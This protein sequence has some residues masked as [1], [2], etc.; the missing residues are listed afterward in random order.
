MTDDD[1]KANFT[2]DTRELNEEG[3]YALAATL[4]EEGIAAIAPV[5]VATVEFRP[6][7]RLARQVVLAGEEFDLA[8]E[9]KNVAG[10]AIRAELV[11][12][13]LRQEAGGLQKVGEKSAT[14]DKESGKGSVRLAVAKGGATCSAP[15]G[16]IASA[17]RS[18][19][20]SRWKSPAM[21]TRRRSGSWS[22]ATPGNLGIRSPRGSSRASTPS[23]PRSSR[24]KGPVFLGIGSLGFRRGEQAR[25]AARGSL[26]PQFTLAIAVVEDWH[27]NEAAKLFTVEKDLQVRV[28]VPKDPLAPGAR[29]WSRSR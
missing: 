1:G 25:G 20:I 13:I 3:T 22:T 26:A 2:L 21:T 14:T 8:L 27:L 10:K 5:Y 17:R 29:R 23:A 16:R 6:A 18:R 12:S 15:K 4:A 7:L 19:A 9:T 24:T 11:V 28:G